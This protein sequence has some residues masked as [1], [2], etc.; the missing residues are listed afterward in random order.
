VLSR[1]VHR[2]QVRAFEEEIDK[3]RVNVSGVDRRVYGPYMQLLPPSQLAVLTLHTTMS[4]LLRGD[5]LPAGGAG[6]DH[7]AN[8]ESGRVRVIK[9]VMA[10]GEMIQAQGSLVVRWPRVAA[11]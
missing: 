3:V 4:L 11:P 5:T 2:A 7:D 10:I 6:S 1:P 8:A 9:L